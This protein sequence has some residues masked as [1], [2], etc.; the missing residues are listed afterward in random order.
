MYNLYTLY[1][2]HKRQCSIA[3]VDTKKK[4]ENNYDMLQ[5]ICDKI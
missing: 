4:A 1:L 2:K 5:S 3:F